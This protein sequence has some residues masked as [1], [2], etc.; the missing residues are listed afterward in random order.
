MNTNGEGFTY[1][2]NTAIDVAKFLES[3][4][5]CAMCRVIEGER[6][7]GIM[8]IWFRKGRSVSGKRTVVA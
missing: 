7:H 1:V 5:P 2:H 6:L 8:L 3:E 4:E